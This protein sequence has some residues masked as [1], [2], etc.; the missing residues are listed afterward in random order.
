[1]CAVRA[2]G[3]GQRALPHPESEKKMRRNRA[4][5]RKRETRASERVRR[6]FEGMLLVRYTHGGGITSPRR[7][8]VPRTASYR[9]ALVENA[10]RPNGILGV[11]HYTHPLSALGASF[12]SRSSS[13]PFTSNIHLHTFLQHPHQI[14]APARTLESTDGTY[15]APE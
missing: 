7:T 13:P 4:R 10:H 9:T 2:L 12:P 6:S 11:D 8:K 15:L 14:P 3:L 1:M 5:R